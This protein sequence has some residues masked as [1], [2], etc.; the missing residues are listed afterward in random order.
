MSSKS[1]PASST[2]NCRDVSGNPATED[3]LREALEKAFSYRGDIT[4]LRQGRHRS[5][6]GYLFDRGFGA[7]LAESLVRL[8]RR[9]G[10][11]NYHSAVRRSPA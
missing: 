7:T 1:S 11:E 5:V 2:R 10:S 8:M 6:E 4:V 3:E 9:D